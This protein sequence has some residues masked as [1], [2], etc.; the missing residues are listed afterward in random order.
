MSMLPK[1]FALL[2]VTSVTCCGCAPI[3]EMHRRGATPVGSAAPVR[4]A[5]AAYTREAPDLQ[6]LFRYYRTASTL[7]PKELDGEYQQASRAFAVK[8]SAENQWRMALLLGIPGSAFYDSTRS[9]TLFK[10]LT[11]EEFH[12]SAELNDAAYLMYSLL[13]AQSQLD[14]KLSAAT[15]RLN[16]SQSANKKM[17]DQLDALKAIESTIYQRNKAEDTPKP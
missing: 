17:Q 7:S 14:K 5:G 2:I 10:E 3:D 12:Q 4:E 6:R 8:R 15:D 1:L 9:S 13:N 11:N 16:E